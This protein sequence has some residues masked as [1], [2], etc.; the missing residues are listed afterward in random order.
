MWSAGVWLLFTVDSPAATPRGKDSD[1]EARGAPASGAELPVLVERDTELAFLR[2]VLEAARGQRGSAVL[3]DGP[4]GI[5]KSALLAAAQRLA[6][7]AA[8]ETETATAR[9]NEREF[10]YGV[11]L[12]LLEARVSQSAPAEQERLLADA[13]ILAMLLLSPGSGGAPASEGEAAALMHGLVRIC[14]N[15]AERQP[16]ALFCRRCTSRR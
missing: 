4:M 8:F 13:G 14:A 3:V 7:D 15:L 5:G 11:A 16:L 9:A 1:L 10:P 6:T 2:G 12:Q